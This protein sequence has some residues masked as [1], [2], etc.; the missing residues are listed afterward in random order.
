MSIKKRTRAGQR[1][2]TVTRGTGDRTTELELQHDLKT[3]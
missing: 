1:K 3:L 2:T